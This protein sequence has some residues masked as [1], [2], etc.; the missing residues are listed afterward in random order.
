[1]PTFAI[2]LIATPMLRAVA[3][4]RSAKSFVAQLA[5]HLTPQMEVIGI[6]A[7]TG[8]MMFYLQRPITVI[9]EDASELTSNY[10]I[11]R[12][13]RFTSNPASPLKPLS[14]LDR[15]LAATNPRVYI[16]RLKD[17]QWQRILE[18]RGWKPIATGAHHVA[19]AR[20]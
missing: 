4:R 2:P 14:Y 7:F 6:E 16:V 17:G 11:R 5:P 20:Q 9:T 19:Y 12:Y 15:S 18:A 8:S 10:L 3:E 13:E 1:L